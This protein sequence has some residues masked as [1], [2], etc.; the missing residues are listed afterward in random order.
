[1][2]SSNGIP[3]GP[4]IK[5]FVVMP[6]G[7]NGEYDGGRKEADFVYEHI[8]R[9]A[10]QRAEE[11]LQRR[12]PGLTIS[13]DRE[14]DNKV[15]GSITASIV[16]KTAYSQLA[17][18]DII[19]LN[20]NAFFELGM[21]YALRSSCTILMRRDDVRIPFDISSYRVI[22]Y[23]KFR[24]TKTVKELAS[25]IAK[26]LRESKATSDSL[27]YDV[28]SEL[29]PPI[30]SA[31]VTDPGNHSIMPWNYFWSRLET[32][33]DT[34]DEDIKDLRYAPDAIIGMSS[35][36]LIVADT[37]GRILFDSRTPVLAIWQQRQLNRRMFDSKINAALLK[38]LDSLRIT[39][40]GR[41]EIL[42]V[43]D[44]TATGK[45]AR[46]ARKYVA[47][48][49]GGKLSIRYLPL[50]CRRLCHSPREKLL[51]YFDKRIKQVRNR[52]EVK[53]LMMTEHTML[54]YRK[55]IIMPG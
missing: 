44:N 18:V 25:V 17:I 19:G 43:D 55:S 42:L 21:H 54:P 13:P 6:S 48:Q 11:R 4:S 12:I 41:L 16:E 37:F 31:V 23:D 52:A 22:S 8:I 47:S 5:A 46:T 49:I 9:A 53:G 10:I 2:K 45:T 14:V 34:I 36:G 35:G 15:T 50:F 27:A 29:T 33:A 20:P 39:K 26:S 38:S 51:L 32:V 40:S 30:A 3:A 28:L 7:T 1:M 24:L